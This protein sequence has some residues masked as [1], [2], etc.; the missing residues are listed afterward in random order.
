MGVSRAL[1]RT[2]REKQV[3]GTENALQNGGRIEGTLS[4]GKPSAT[5]SESSATPG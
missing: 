5:S 1:E 3:F 2:V 4:D